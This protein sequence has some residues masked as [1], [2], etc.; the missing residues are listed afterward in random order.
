MNCKIKPTVNL[1]ECQEMDLDLRHCSGIRVEVSRNTEANLNQDSN[2]VKRK[3]I[4][5][6]RNLQEICEK[7]SSSQQ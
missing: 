1:E 4:I 2:C 5:L 7:R 3:V 6:S